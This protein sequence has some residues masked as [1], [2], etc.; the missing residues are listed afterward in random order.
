MRNSSVM[1]RITL[2]G[3]RAISIDRNLSFHPIINLLKHWAQINDKDTSVSALSKLE[4]AIRSVCPEDTNEI[5][6]FVATLMR[7]KLSG[8][9]A[10]RVS[11][12]EGEA[13]EKLIFKNMRDLLIKSTEQ[14]PLVVVIEDLHW[15]DT[16]SI[17]LLE[18][19]F[20]L[21]ET[22]RIVFINVFRPNHPETGDRIIETI[23]KNCLFIMLK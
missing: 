10:E 21:A 13:L 18:S 19:M 2:L 8:R 9:H 22:R 12:I 7:M 4:T 1:K 5:F 15:A 3:G 14:T 11:G 23:K 6:P 17:E 20:R 16:S